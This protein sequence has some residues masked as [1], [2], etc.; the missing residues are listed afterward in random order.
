M[1]E[2]HPEHELNPPELHDPTHLVAPSGWCAPSEQLYDPLFGMTDEERQAA[3]HAAFS[4]PGDYI[5]DDFDDE[6]DEVQPRE[7][8]EPRNRTVTRDELIA[9]FLTRWPDE[10]PNQQAEAEDTADAF[11][12][13]FFG[14]EVYPPEEPRIIDLNTMIIPE[15]NPYAA[16]FEETT[17]ALIDPSKITKTPILIKRATAEPES[18]SVEKISDPHDDSYPACRHCGE[19]IQ[20]IPFALG[21]EWRHWPTPYGNYNTNEMYR[22]CRNTTSAE[23]KPYFNHGPE[24]NG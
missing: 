1:T 24:S 4:W 18:A 9:F 2:Q 21:P 17:P 16:L 3:Q 11:I 5:E 10:D 22:H 8:P 20:Y 23:P 12:K 14:V 6:D 15:N 13:E 19:R 7:Q